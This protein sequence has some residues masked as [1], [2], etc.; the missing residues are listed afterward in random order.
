MGKADKIKIQTKKLGRG[1]EITIKESCPFKKGGSI[2]KL[3]HIECLYGL[4][5]IKVPRPAC[6]LVMGV[7]L[8]IK[9]TTKSE[10]ENE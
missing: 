3:E 4:S 8:T 6:P 2:C 1:T 5:E 10:A 7:V 9:I